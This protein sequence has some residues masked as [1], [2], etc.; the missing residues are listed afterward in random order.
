MLQRAKEQAIKQIEKGENLKAK[1]M[2][3][4][5]QFRLTK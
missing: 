2:E 1:V 5:K 3:Y 4:R